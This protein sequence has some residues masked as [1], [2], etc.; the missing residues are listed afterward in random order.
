VQV[1]VDADMVEEKLEEE[2]EVGKKKEKKNK[3]DE[4][5][6]AKPK[7]LVQQVFTVTA[8]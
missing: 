5:T 6:A 2:D 4:E 7:Q 1:E 8:Y 3:V